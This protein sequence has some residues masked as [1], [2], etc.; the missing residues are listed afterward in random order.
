MSFLF[1]QSMQAL[2]VSFIRKAIP[3][4]T[5][6]VYGQSTLVC[7]LIGNRI[8]TVAAAAEKRL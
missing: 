8:K 7:R 3:V 6:E 4:L 1:E 5:E 2:A